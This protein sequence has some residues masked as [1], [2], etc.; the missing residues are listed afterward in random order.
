[1]ATVSCASEKRT[2]VPAVLEPFASTT[3]KSGGEPEL[4]WSL[5]SPATGDLFPT[6]AAVGVDPAA[7]MVELG[8]DLFAV[9]DPPPPQAAIVNAMI[10]A[11]AVLLL[12]GPS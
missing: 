7:L 12:I 3:A 2:P 5:H 4:S 9:C 10:R 1:M 8:L 11:G 6:V